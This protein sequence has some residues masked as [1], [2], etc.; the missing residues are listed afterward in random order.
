MFERFF[1][2]GKKQNPEP[3]NI[4]LQT[5]KMQSGAMI[6]FVLSALSWN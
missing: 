5:G 6:L 1:A 4:W 2:A 3:S